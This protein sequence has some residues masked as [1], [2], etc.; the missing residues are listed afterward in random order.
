MKRPS[1]VFLF[2]FFSHAR[3][4]MQLNAINTECLDIVKIDLLPFESHTATQ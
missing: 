3:Y 1:R 2:I 4:T